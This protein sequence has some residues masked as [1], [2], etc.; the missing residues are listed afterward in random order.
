MKAPTQEV[1]LHTRIVPPACYG[2]LIVLAAAVNIVAQ[3]V[4]R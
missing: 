3:V 4:A 1:S 2:A